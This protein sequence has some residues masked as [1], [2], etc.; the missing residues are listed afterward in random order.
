MSDALRQAWAADVS[1][2]RG[3][4]RGRGRVADVAQARFEV[5]VRF[6][7]P[8]LDEVAALVGSTPSHVVAR[9]TGADLE[10]A[11]LGFSPGFAYLHG[12]PPDLA[13][14]ARRERPRP[15]V[16]AGSVALGGGFAA[17]Y[18]QSAPGGWHLVG[19]SDAE[20]FDPERPP[21]ASLAPGRRVRLVST[22]DDLAPPP[23]LWRPALSGAGAA[24]LAVERGGAC[25]LVEDGGRIGVA[26]LGVPR[27]GA[28]DPVAARLANR[29]LGNP[30]DVAVLEVTAAG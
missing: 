12:L 8:D 16:P 17:V 29:L 13:V 24:G 1:H 11:F 25:T 6:D 5:R 22:E 7:G 4:G 15:V 9:L 23:P 18:P 30:D 14:L 26:A 19:R 10:V 27:A 21:Y 20:L 28:A 3:R 2:P